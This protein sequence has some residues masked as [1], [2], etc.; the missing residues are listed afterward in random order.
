VAKK[1]TRARSLSLYSNL[2]HKRKTK[3]DAESRKRAQYL[4]SLPKHPVKRFFYRLHPKR[5]FHYWFSKRGGIMALKIVGVALLVLCLLVGGLFAYYRKD[6]DSISPGELAKRVQTTVTTYEDRDGN[7]L[8]QDTGG[9]NYKLVVAS[10]ELS[11]YLKNATVAIEDKDFYKNNGIS[12]TGLA[13]ATINNFTGGSTQGA[14]TLTQQLI[15]QVFFSDEAGDRGLSGIPRKIKEIILSLE[16]ERMYDKD[17]ILSLYLNESPYGGPRNGA[18][19]AAETYFGVHAK[20]LTLSEAALLAAIPQDPN[21]FNPYNVPG[22]A[23][24]ISR[25][26]TVLDD[27]AAQGYIT[28][29]QADAAKADPVLDKLQPESNTDASMQA[30]W[31]VQYVRSQLVSQLGASVVGQGGLTIKTTLDSDIENK[32]EAAMTTEFA[33]NVLPN[34]YGFSNGASTVEDTATGQ[35]V[36]MVGSRSYDYPGFGQVNAATAYIQPGS[37]IKPLVYSQLFQQKATG[38]ANFGSGSKLINNDITGIYGQAVTNANGDPENSGATTIR[39][40][41]ANSWNIPAIEAMAIDGVSQSI[42]TIRALGGTSYCTQGPDTTVQLAAAIGGCGI[43]QV[44][45]VNAYASLGRGGVYIPQSDVLSVTNTSG[46]VLE[47]WTQPA[48]TQVVNPQAAYTVS[49]ILHD[50]NARTFVGKHETGMYI[51]GVDSAA[52]TGTSNATNAAGSPKDIWMVNYSQSLTMAVWLGNPDTTP[53]KNNATSIVPGPILDSVLQYAYK[54]DY[55]SQGKWKPGD[56]ITQPAGIQRIGCS[57][58]NVLVTGNG[59]FDQPCGEVYPSYWNAN[60]GL[61]NTNFDSVTKKLAT[62]CTPS[63]AVVTVSVIKIPLI[64]SVA[65]NQALYVDPKGTY[66]LAGSLGDGAGDCSTAS[67]TNFAPTITAP[68]YSGTAGNYTVSATAT[69]TGT[70]TIASVTFTIAGQPYTV[71]TPTAGVYTMS[72]PHTV[73]VP[74]SSTT[75]Y[76]TAIDSAGQTSQQTNFAPH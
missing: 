12:I 1:P 24:L 55:A 26:H 57:T 58:G 31:F 48:G 61:I 44:D 22:N 71:T 36:A 39:T 43:K 23:A 15:K 64:S 54:T 29:A 72:L 76:A 62:S 9:G 2:S 40:G 27:M 19:S 42:K 38:A 50:D 69:A 14:S 45:L 30:P 49:D 66:T 63:D 3:K 53:L 67:A 41:L 25:Q 68:T 73:V 59:K 4:A 60:A 8:W 21:Y 46:E 75:D 28:K 70:N 51:P 10:D 47:K 56:W 37:T 35:I 65:P 74:P 34:R 18:E 33:G 32:L 17:Q 11:P 7:V 5:V 13:R 52:K 6:L 20:D 16:V